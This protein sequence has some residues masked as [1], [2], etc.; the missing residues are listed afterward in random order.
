MLLADLGI[1]VVGIGDTGD[2]A[3]AMAAEMKP[4]F[5]T[6]D[7]KLPGESRR[8]QHRNRDF[9]AARHPVDFRLGLQ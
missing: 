9:R 3:L 4:D 2:K 8:H 5:L 1:E 7:I 6:M